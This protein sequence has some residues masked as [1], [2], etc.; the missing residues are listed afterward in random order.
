MAPLLPLLSLVPLLWYP[1]PPHFL[2]LISEHL[3]KESG[4]RC[5]PQITAGMD[6]TSYCLPAS[7]MAVGW[8][9]CPERVSRYTMKTVAHALSA[10]G[11]H[12]LP[13]ETFSIRR[14]L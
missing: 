6:R 9:L 2:I 12:A 3:P 7:L 1:A 4:L 14:P 5:G 10:E 11:W 8:T 13:K